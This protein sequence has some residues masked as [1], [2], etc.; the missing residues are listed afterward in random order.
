MTYESDSWGLPGS[1]LHRFAERHLDRSVVEMIVLPII[2][3]LQHE[4]SKLPRTAMARPLVLLRG[5]WSFWKAIGLHTVI[6]GDVKMRITKSVGVD[7]FAF[8]LFSIA[9]FLFFRLGY[10]FHPNLNRSM[11]FWSAQLLGCLACLAIALAVRARITAYCIA[12]F[13]AFTASEI[14]VQAYQTV[15]LKAP[16]SLNTVFR[17]PDVMGPR[18]SVIRVMTVR[19]APQYIAVIGAALLGV[20]LGAVLALWGSKLTDRSRVGQGVPS[21]DNL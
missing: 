14:V 17:A 10:M 13:V 7:A 11:I 21:A 9:A 16:I 18:P 1:R 3:D 2:A 19:F 12:G 4:Y 8:V 5:Y 6:S 15:F 20:A